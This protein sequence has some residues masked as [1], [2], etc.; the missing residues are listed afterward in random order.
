[1]N[2]GACSKTKSKVALA[3]PKAGGVLSPGDRL[4]SCHPKEEILN[5]GGERSAEKELGRKTNQADGD[6]KQ[7]QKKN[8]GAD[9]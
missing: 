8:N 6:N 9:F 5:N 2:C 1:M 7:N 4:F 3:N